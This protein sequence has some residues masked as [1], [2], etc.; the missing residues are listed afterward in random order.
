MPEVA[1]DAA[2][3]MKDPDDAEGLA[4][5]LK[6]LVENPL[7]RR[8]WVEKGLVQAGRFSWRNTAEATFGAFEQT[9]RERNI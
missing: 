7:H 1:G 6:E 3:Y 4:K 9:F 8:G 5:I 2:L